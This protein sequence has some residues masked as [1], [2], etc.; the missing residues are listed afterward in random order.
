MLPPKTRSENRAPSATVNRHLKVDRALVQ[1][2]LRGDHKAWAELIDR[3][4]RLVYSVARGLCAADDVSDVFQQVWLDCYERLPELRNV[5]ALPAWLITV[6]K[7]RAYSIYK[8]AQRFRSIEE[9]LA[10]TSS[11]LVERIEREHELERV[12]SELSEP[13]H[14]L[15]EL[16]YFEV[17]EPSYAEVS[18]RM[19]MPIPSIGPTRGRCLEKL[20]KLLS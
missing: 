6:T 1:R 13:C 7:R 5:D 14:T 17:T 9:G 10:D 11:D 18:E 16:L 3:Y 4:Q 12:L 8:A 2:C 20:R 19:G 15:I